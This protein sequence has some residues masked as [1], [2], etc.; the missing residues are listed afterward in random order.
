MQLND[1]GYTDS[2][3]SCCEDLKVVMLNAKASFR[4]HILND[5]MYSGL[6][7][8]RIM[9]MENRLM[10]RWARAGKGVKSPS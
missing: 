8:D 3:G 4:R 2:A 1:K 9:E 6:Q 7:N 10:R 5:S